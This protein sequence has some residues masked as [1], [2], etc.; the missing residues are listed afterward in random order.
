MA[1]KKEEKATVTVTEEKKEPVKRACKT[2]TERTEK[3]APKNIRLNNTRNPLKK[4]Q[5]FM[6]TITHCHSTPY[7]IEH[8]VLI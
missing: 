3:S 8:N 1:K 2:K 5:K 7:Y 6:F 4:C